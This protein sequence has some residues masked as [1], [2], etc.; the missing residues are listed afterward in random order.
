MKDEAYKIWQDL[1]RRFVSGEALDE[2]ERAEYE[3]GCRE[4]DAEEK[5]DG[6]LDRLRALRAQIMEAK[7]DQQQLR[8]QEQELDAR[9]AAMEAR[10]DKRTRE[11]L[12]IGD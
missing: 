12:G 2:T 4:L 9:V 1:H 6:N 10:L 5:L 8:A 7:L 3:A 11:L